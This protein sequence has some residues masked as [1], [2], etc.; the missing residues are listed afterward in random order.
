MSRKKGSDLGSQSNGV[1]EEPAT[2]RNRKDYTFYVV[3]DDGTREE[4]GLT[5]HSPTEARAFADWYQRK[6]ENDGVDGKVVT[7]V[8][9]YA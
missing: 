7:G 1:V 9:T 5:L 4:V 8:F 2:K 6:L 3:K